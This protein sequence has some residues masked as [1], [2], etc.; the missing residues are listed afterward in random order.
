ME[1]KFTLNNPE[2]AEKAVKLKG[3][4]FQTFPCFIGAPYKAA[5]MKVKSRHIRDIKESFYL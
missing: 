1:P 2:S 3:H 4:H 5:S